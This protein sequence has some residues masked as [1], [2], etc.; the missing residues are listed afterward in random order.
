MKGLSVVITIL[1]LV[2]ADQLA[3]HL[4]RA[5]LLPANEPVPRL[6]HPLR[7]RRQQ[8]GRSGSVP[9]PLPTVPGLAPRASVP[10]LTLRVP[11]DEIFE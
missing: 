3:T 6:V 2:L 10:R 4:K 9:P 7:A 1:L 11:Y 5:A 8:T